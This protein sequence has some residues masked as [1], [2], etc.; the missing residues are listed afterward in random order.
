M[1]AEGALR[2]IIATL[3]AWIGFRLDLNGKYRLRISLQRQPSLMP[4]GA[5]LFPSSSGFHQ[6]DAVFGGVFPR[7]SLG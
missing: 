7:Q 3:R 4:D 2:V 1:D 5:A 6:W